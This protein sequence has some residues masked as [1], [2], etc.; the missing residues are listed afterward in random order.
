ML[1]KEL[2][3]WFNKKNCKFVSLSVNANNNAR[4][5]YQKWGFEIFYLRMIKKL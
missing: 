2:L 1:W 3:A 4:K 5:I